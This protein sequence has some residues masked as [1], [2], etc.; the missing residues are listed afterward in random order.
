MLFK[1]SPGEL[2]AAIRSKTD[3]HFGLYHSLF[4]W[5]HPL[6]LQDQ[7]HN[8]STDYFVKVSQLLYISTEQFVI[9]E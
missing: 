6:Y 7:K 9:K 5:F 8:F 4:E 1:I 2:A 3:I